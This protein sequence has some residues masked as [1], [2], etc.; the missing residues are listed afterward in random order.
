MR[1][2]R[3]ETSSNR[4]KRKYVKRSQNQEK[5]IWK[6]VVN[7]QGKKIGKRDHLGNFFPYK[8]RG[9]L[10]KN[11]GTKQ[12]GLNSPGGTSIEVKT[13]KTDIELEDML[14]AEV[15]KKENTAAEGESNNEGNE[16]TQS[17][18]ES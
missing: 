15:Q 10:P 8:K 16:G 9:R 3:A 17:N 2:S 14:A 13:Q 12:A 11:L 4:P 6:V 1:E 5:I 18:S 7:E